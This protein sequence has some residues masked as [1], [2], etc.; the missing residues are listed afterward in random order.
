MS[1]LRIG[2]VPY[3]NAKPLVDWFHEPEC[4]ADAEVTYAVPAELAA[5]LRDGELDV[6]MVSVFE[7]FRGPGLSMV[8]GVSV[9]ADGPVGSVR[10]LSRVSPRRIGS[11]A[12]DTS[13]LTSAALTR[14][15][16]SEVYRLQ[17]R[18]VPHPPDLPAMLAV[19]DA[20]LIIGDLRLFARPASHVIDLGA[21][22]KAHTGLPFV[23]A[24]WLARDDGP[25][26][27][28]AQILTRARDWGVSHLE[29]LSTRWAE[30]MGLPLARVRDYFLNVMRY[31]L[32]ESAW[33]G[34]RT[35]QER[36][37]AHGLVETRLPLRLVGE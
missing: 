6:A 7:L 4:D 14:V 26:A 2:S 17:P 24:G 10:L 33:T 13:S 35:F 21:E 1:A 18:Y 27:A 37:V 31:G 22:W 12:L 16:L 30:R 11:V 5:R 8:P 3:L 29:A 36:C 25:A 23:Y 15:L 32:D 20:A 28:A 34:L 9:S 19:C